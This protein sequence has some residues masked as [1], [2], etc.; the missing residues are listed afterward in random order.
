[1]LLAITMAHMQ[2]TAVIPRYKAVL[3]EFKIPVWLVLVDDFS[4]AAISSYLS[5]NCK[6]G[7]NNFQLNQYVLPRNQSSSTCSYKK[8]KSR[9]SILV[10]YGLLCYS[11]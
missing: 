4:M 3:K 11:N 10:S 2:G 8:I 1:M 6:R 7:V 9:S 5:M